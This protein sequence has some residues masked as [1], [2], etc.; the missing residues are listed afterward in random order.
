MTSSTLGMSMRLRDGADA[1]HGVSSG[2]L[3]GTNTRMEFDFKGPAAHRVVVVGGGFGGISTVKALV[4]APVQITLIDQTNHHLFQPLLYQVATG[5]LSSGQ[6]A[7]AL[8]SLFRR[9]DNVEVLLGKV[10]DV[11]LERHVVKMLAEQEIEV[12]FDTLVIAAGATHSYLGHDDWEQWAPG[13]KTLDDAIRLRTRILSAFELA[14][15]APSKEERDAWLTF[16]IVGGG[17]TGVE[18][19]AQIALLAH[20]VLRGEYHHIDPSTARVILLDAVPTL[21]GDFPTTLRKRAERDLRRL[22]VDVQLESPVVG[23]DPDG[24]TIGGADRSRRIDAKTVLWAAGVRASPLGAILAHASGGQTD[25]AGRLVVGPDLTLP[26]HPEVFAIGDMISIP[27][28]PGVA[29]PA[30][31]EG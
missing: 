28:V 13:M 24:V 21:L 10:E 25:K 5:V 23:G 26:G 4:D 3:R 7:P 6:I 1:P 2:Q 30:M 19:S 14:E 20:R 15:Q 16:A 22:G 11:D 29:Q 8:R 17:P 18:L 12:P 31:Q 9:E 27:G